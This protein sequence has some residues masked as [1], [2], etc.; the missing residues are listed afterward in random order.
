M[1]RS[2]SRK[3]TSKVIRTKPKLWESVKNRIKAGS[4][5]GKPGQWSARKAQLS[6]AEYKKKGGGY[7]GKSAKPKNTS[8]GKWTRQKWG[9]KSGKNSIVG[10]KATGERYLPKKARNALSKEEYRKTSAKKRRD[11]KK[12]IQHSKQPKKIA[13]KTSPYRMNTL[14]NCCKTTKKDKSC[15]RSSDGKKFTLPR[16]FS[17]KQCKNQ[18]GFTMKASCAPYKNCKPIGKSKKVKKYR[19]SPKKSRKRISKK[20]PRKKSNIKNSMQCNK[21]RKS[22]KPEKKKMVKG[23]SNGKEKLIHY[24]ATGY[25]NNY[26]AKARKSFKARHKCSSANDKLTARYWACKDLW[27]GPGGDTRSPPK[28]KRR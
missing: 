10:K 27:A 15:K 6:V 2:K 16:K 25:G 4:K 20:L 13:K 19:I 8:L 26:S 22:T 14:K 12:G 17:K 21:P 7:S 18:R 1:P 28:R 23:C 24:G 3:R 11:T 9:T 5:G